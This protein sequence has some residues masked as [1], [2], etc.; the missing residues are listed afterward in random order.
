MFPT[1]MTHDVSDHRH[2]Q[3][4]DHA[5]R[6]NAVQAARRSGAL[7][8]DRGAARRLT[9]ARLGEMLA[10]AKAAVFPKPATTP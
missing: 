1:H 2:R 6:I 8:V 7:D 9:V 5:A 4:L 3:H 10:T